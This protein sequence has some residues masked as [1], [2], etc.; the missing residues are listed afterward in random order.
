M[1]R[2][3]RLARRCYP[4]NMTARFQIKAELTGRQFS[5][6]NVTQ[7]GRVRGGTPNPPI[8]CVIGSNPIVRANFFRREALTVKQETLNLYN[9]DR[10]PAR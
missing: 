10:Y 7:S 8:L 9:R 2:K 6:A 1:L 5:N 3:H 4:F